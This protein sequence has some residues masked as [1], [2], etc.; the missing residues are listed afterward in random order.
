MEA[1]L[2]DAIKNILKYLKYFSPRPGS[3]LRHPRRPRQPRPRL[4]SPG[5]TGGGGRPGLLR[6]A[7]VK[8]FHCLKKYFI[9]N[10]SFS[11]GEDLDTAASDAADPL[12]MLQ[13]SI[14]GVPGEDYPI[15]AEV[16]KYFIVFE[17]IL[18]LF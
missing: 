8:I 1:T 17:N 5:Q 7:Q 16:K 2:T 13:A 6:P 12:A 4:P 3:E 9:E 15:Y 14:P 11:Y 10:I 18:L